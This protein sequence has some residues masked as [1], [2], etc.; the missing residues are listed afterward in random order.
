MEE[1]IVTP[2]SQ[3]IPS[4]VFEHLFTLYDRNK[5][6]YITRDELRQIISTFS[7]DVKDKTVDDLL[8]KHDLNKSGH[9]NV[10]EFDTFMHELAKGGYIVRD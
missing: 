2:A 8:A 3:E 7:G 1:S 5:D 6:G 4:E 10:E 9:L